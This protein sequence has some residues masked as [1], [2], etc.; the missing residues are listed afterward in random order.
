VVLLVGVWA[1][2]ENSSIVNTEILQNVTQSLELG[3]YPLERPKK[4]KLV[5]NSLKVFENKAP[6]RMVGPKREEVRRG[7]I[8]LHKENLHNLYSSPNIIR[9]FKS[10]SMGGACSTHERDEKF[11]RNCC[12]EI[13]WE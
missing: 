8:K 2:A 3:G 9:V 11:I 1:E 7:K 4:W 10:R 12:R 6:G 13:L 5:K